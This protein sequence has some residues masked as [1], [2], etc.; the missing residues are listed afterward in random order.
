MTGGPA[1][2]FS[3]TLVCILLA[4]GSAPAQH[5]EIPL[6]EIHRRV[7]DLTGTLPDD[8]IRRL[9]S[10]LERFERETSNQIAVLMIPSLNGESIEDY[11]MRVAEKNKFGKR[12]R[13]N[14]ILVLIV[15][16]DHRMRIEVGY[17]LEGVLTDALCDQIIRRVMAPKFR[18]G[19]YAGGIEAGVDA[20]MF[21][22][23]GEFKGEPRGNGDLRRFT[24]IL[25]LLV[26]LFFAFM[27]R[28]LGGRRHYV[29]S[30]GYYSGPWF[31][32][33]GGGGFSG[34]GFGGGGGG[35]S[36][37]G[38]SFGGGGASGSW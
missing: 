26:F 33:F 30:R 1:N 19:D 12:G 31:G 20:I 16:E 11:S 8:G 15:K 32:G 9:E 2:S 29:G 23:K 27:N 6:P 14:G 5:N 17:G 28:L 3:L 25:L 7:T 21:A 13:D 22:T 34:G 36:G 38:G 10:A 35:F 4:A 24:P 37:G 18:D